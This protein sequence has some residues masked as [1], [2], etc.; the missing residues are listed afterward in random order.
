MV[1]HRPSAVRSYKNTAILFLS[2]TTVAG[3]IVA[4]QQH[5]ELARLREVAIKVEG[6]QPGPN[7]FPMAAEPDNLDAGIGPEDDLSP[8]RPSS[9][10]TPSTVARDQRPNQSRA[11]YR[12]MMDRPE[13]Q[14]LIAIGQKSSL[15]G[16][17]SALFKSLSLTPDQLET[18]KEL[19]VEKR[20]EGNTLLAAVPSYNE[21]LEAHYNIDLVFTH[22][23]LN[24]LA[25]F[26]GNPATPF[27]H[28]LEINRTRCVQSKVFCM[29]YVLVY[30]GSFQQGLCGNATPVKAN[31]PKAFFFN[32]SCL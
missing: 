5:Q 8:P 22:Q 11:D 25:H 27:D 20:T 24:A 2:L 16:R 18:F 28:S 7:P 13:I 6:P 17:Y 31:A 23:E 9:G 30:L 4:W 26:V 1:V 12:A 15:D 3:A 29:L 10:P 32:D 14:R 19:L 21:E